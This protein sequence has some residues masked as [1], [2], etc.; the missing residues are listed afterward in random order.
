MPLKLLAPS[1]S[2]SSFSSS[3]E[4]TLQLF[5]VAAYVPSASTVFVKSFPMFLKAARI[6]PAE[7]LLPTTGS[8]FPAETVSPIEDADVD[9]AFVTLRAVIHIA[10]NKSVHCKDWHSHKRGMR[11]TRAPR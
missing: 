9:G 4:P 3:D 5:V 2:S 1:G 11:A 8:S 6:K 7:G 10:S